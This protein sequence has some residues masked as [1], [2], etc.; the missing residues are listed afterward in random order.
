[1][2]KESVNLPPSLF[3][4][5]G[6][7]SRE[8]LEKTWQLINKHGQDISSQRGPVKSIKGVSLIIHNPLAGTDHDH[9]PYW[10][11][12]SDDWYQDNFVRKETNQP[13]QIIGQSMIFPYKYVWRSRQF[14]NGWGY[15]Q[16]TAEL[17]T[18]HGHKTIDFKS[19]ADLVSF[20][21]NVSKLYHPESVLAVLAW[22]GTELMNLYLNQ[23]DVLSK[24]LERNQSDTLE[25]V[26]DEINTSPGSRRAITPA[27]TLEQIDHSGAAGGVP[28]YQNYQLLTEYDSTGKP[29]GIISCHLHRSF[30][31]KGGTQLDVSHDRDWG[32]LASKKTGLPLTKMIIYCN[33]MYYFVSDDD[34]HQDLVA[35]TDIKSWLFAV[36]DAYDPTKEDIE[37][38]LASPLYQR[39][40][41][42]TWNVLKS[43]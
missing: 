19:K 23:P 31:A 20:V 1:M 5:E 9:Y 11:K 28:V 33:D 32:H 12:Q 21:K 16:A 34:S 42:Y 7:S 27:F 36:T 30:D 10:D 24:L 22:Q 8:V 37:K 13:S 14:D 2:P 6:D 25:T 41:D 15:V 4:I 35:Q 29:I 38:R 43:R 3:T 40:I 17:L 39:K 18:S 26:I